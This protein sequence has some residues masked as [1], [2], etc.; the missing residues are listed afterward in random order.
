M[1]QGIDHKKDIWRTV[2][3]TVS[4]LLLLGILRYLDNRFGILTNLFS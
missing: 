3:L 2:I 1:L 4:I